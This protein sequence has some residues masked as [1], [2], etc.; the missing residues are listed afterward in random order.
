ME[1]GLDF[2]ALQDPLLQGT[3]AYYFTYLDLSPETVRD[4]SWWKTVLL[5][6][7]EKQLQCTTMEKLAV[8]FGDGSGVDTGGTKRNTEYISILSMI[9]HHWQNLMP[10]PSIN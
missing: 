5:N 7:L 3:K 1:L 2:H 9:V 4:L 6:G 8:T 10:L